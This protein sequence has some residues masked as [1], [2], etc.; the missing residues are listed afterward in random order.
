MI[1]ITDI[2]RSLDISPATVSRAL[3]QSR[4]VTPELTE[5]VSVAAK[6]LGYKKR[7]IRR[8][9][10]RAILNIKLVLPHHKEPERALFFDL[11]ALIEGIRSGFKHCGI[12]LLCETVSPKFNPYP[13]KK[14]GDLDG[15]IFAFNRP[16]P[17]TLQELHTIG[18]PF[19]VLNREIPDLPCV[20]SE[21]AKGMADIIAHL[22]ERRPGLKP[23]FVTL[24]G[25]GQ[26]GEERL[27]GM[28]AACEEHGLPFDPAVDAFHFEGISSLTADAVRSMAET[29]NA[30][31]CAN[32][33][34]GSVV[35]AE[36]ERLGI[37]IPA[38]ISVTGFDNSPLRNLTRPLLTTV[39]MPIAKLAVA[40]AS[41]LESQIIEH[42]IP[43]KIVRIPGVLMVGESS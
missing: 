14:G 11:A 32:D 5:K 15:F 28:I 4:L 6:E 24:C 12:N 23:A 20:A 21:N 33:I 38:R 16:S 2:A 43:E 1:T 37:P 8:H 9:R 22:N 3:N 7:S 30:L 39:S 41:N 42:K 13:H 26:V 10:G 17:A 18:T 31:V 40:A 27:G 36:V 29:Y 35:I 25:L 34:I 19:V